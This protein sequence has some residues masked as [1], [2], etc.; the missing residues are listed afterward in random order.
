[1]PDPAGPLFGP[2][3]LVLSSGAP[4]F[5][6]RVFPDA[7][8]AE[9]AAAEQP[10]RYYFQAV[11]VFLAHRDGGPE[12]DFSMNA[13]AKRPR[14]GAPAVEYL[15]GTCT[16]ATTLALPESVPTD[17]LDKI[18]RHDHPDPP[19]RIAHLF[20]YRPTAPTPDV[21][22]V[23]ITRNTVS[24]TAA[25][26]R[27]SS[28]DITLTAQ[29]SAAGSIEIHGHNTF[30]VSCD[31]AATEE[32]V[33]SLRDASAP[34]LSVTNTLI[35]Q[36]DTGAA[37]LTIELQIDLDRLYAACI[38]DSS[39]VAAAVYR[40]GQAANAIRHQITDAAGHPID[41]ALSEWLDHSDAL[42]ATVFGM[43]AG[44]LFDS[45][46]N[47]PT[48]KTDRAPSGSMLRQSSRLCGQIS[49][50]QTLTAEFD[51]LRAAVKHDI[52]PYLTVLD[53]GI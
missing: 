2:D 45:G 47:G 37:S 20:N 31:A 34:P 30:L 3:A 6:V 38:A 40:A 53:I 25:H 9:L 52:G 19:A 10:T 28:R 27:A 15:G 50:Q 21:V 44:D 4:T 26:T 22:P 33:R 1:M 41:A 32:I 51:D 48:L 5:D 42:P 8:N 16:F 11:T 49:A 36:F 14:P 18:I 29:Y 7:R 46:P 13:L 17:V 23:P 39:V 12:L 35:E 24:C 43:V